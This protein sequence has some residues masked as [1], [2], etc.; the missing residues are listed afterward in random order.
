MESINYI[1]E[2]SIKYKAL[3]SQ[4]FQLET[5]KSA[6]Q[7]ISRKIKNEAQE[8]FVVLC[9]NTR[10]EVVHYCPVTKGTVSQSL[11]HPREVLLP[12]LQSGSTAFMIAHNHP[13]GSLNPSMDDD[14]VTKELKQAGELIGIQLLEHIIVAFGTSGYYSY[15][16]EGRID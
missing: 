11:V 16:E 6:A 9:L 15:K 13:S 12:V 2:I 8:N 5:P 10:N 4:V 1:R 7:F 3:R 14:K